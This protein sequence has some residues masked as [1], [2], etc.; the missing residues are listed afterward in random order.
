M[1]WFIVLIFGFTFLFGLDLVNRLYFYKNQCDGLHKWHYDDKGD[2]R[3]KTCKI[4]AAD[5]L[6]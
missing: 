6:D 4:K 2:M 3:C 5:N 1:D